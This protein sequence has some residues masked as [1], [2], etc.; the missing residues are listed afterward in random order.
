LAPEP[1]IATWLAALDAQIRRSPAF[2][3]G[4]PIVVDLAAIPPED[5]SLAGLMGELQA[6]G[7][8]VVASEAGG[9]PT[10]EYERWG[11]PP[12]LVGGRPAGLAEPPQSPAPPQPAPPARAAAPEPSSLLIAKPVRSGQS[13]IFPTGDV[14]VIGAVSSGAEVIAGNSIHVYGALRGR[15]VA[16]LM[17]NGQ[18]RIFCRR[19]E[20]ELVA[21]EGRYLTADMMDAALRGRAVQVW[22]DGDR[23]RVAALD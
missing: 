1:P 17:G 4:R 14:T 18:A 11:F 22:L 12:P 6:R 13:I 9:G 20:A 8:H 21:I 15:A 19:L 2:F 16:G 5:A 3:A 23:V 10:E 7:M